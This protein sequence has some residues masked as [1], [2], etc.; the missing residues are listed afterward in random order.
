M[1]SVRSPCA[2][3]SVSSGTNS[4]RGGFGRPSA[5]RRPRRPARRRAASATPRTPT[6]RAPPRR[7]QRARAR[8]SPGTTTSPGTATSPS[9]SP[10]PPSPPSPGPSPEL[11]R[12]P[13]GLRQEA[14]RDARPE[15]RGGGERV[16]T[17]LRPD[18]HQVLAPAA[19]GR[20]K[21]FVVSGTRL[22][23]RFGARRS[24]ARR[25]KQSEPLARVG[26]R[27]C[28]P[29]RARVRHAGEWCSRRA[30]RRFFFFCDAFVV[31]RV[32]R[33]GFGQHGDVLRAGRVRHRAIQ[34]AVRQELRRVVV[35]SPGRR[36][37][38]VV[39]VIDRLVFSFS[40]SS[41][42]SDR[43]AHRGAGPAGRSGTG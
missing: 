11:Q 36:F 3:A 19:T 21:R 40:S 31:L 32:E 27:Q 38:V 35:E 18:A 20:R 24:R 26:R 15:R 30:R 16:G 5:S 9:P 17:A 41:R 28:S 6:R 12:E 2:T 13:H 25:A 29:R 23:T 22:G 1:S 7:R 34:H 42:R 4:V 43:R 8:A 33:R 39:V 10:S 14:H 37:R